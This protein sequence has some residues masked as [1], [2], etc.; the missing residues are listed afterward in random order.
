MRQSNHQ[1]T[2]QSDEES[3]APH[4]HTRMRDEEDEE[5]PH[6]QKPSAY[7][8]PAVRIYRH[9]LESI[10]EML[11]LADLS[12]TLAVSP[13]WSAAVRS[14]KPI[15]ASIEFDKHSSIERHLVRLL[16]PIEGFVASPLLRHLGTIHISHADESTRLDNA[17]LALLTAHAPNLTLLS[18]T[19]VITSMASLILPAKLQSLHLTLDVNFTGAVVDAVVL[20]ALVALPSLSCLSLTL[21]AFVRQSPIDLSILSACPSL[22]DLTLGT[23]NGGPPMLTNAQV[24]QIRLFL[25]HLRRFNVGWMNADDLA[26][27]LQP[28]VTA[29]W[30]D[31]GHVYADVRIGEPLLRLPTLTRL[32]LPDRTVPQVRAQICTVV[33]S[34]RQADNDK[35]HDSTR[36]H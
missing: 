25:G 3:A 34:V 35:A 29:R 7:A 21:A 31:I 13:E 26:R 32:E 23:K 16:P 8:S 36:S 5:N 9:A 22:T 11:N 12:H 6:S 28:P 30:Q 4:T 17:S 10:F 1:T 19:L 18:C 2:G 15:H 14:M 20:T 33:C 27:F 24:K